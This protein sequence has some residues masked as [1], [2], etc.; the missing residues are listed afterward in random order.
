CLSAG[1][2]KRAAALAEAAAQTAGGDLSKSLAVHRAAQDVLLA[3]GK[4]E[5]LVRLYDKFYN[6]NVADPLR[7]YLRARVEPDPDRRRDDLEAALAR[8]TDLFWA[9][10]DLAE[11]YAER[12][13]WSH[14]AR[15]AERAVEIRPGE[16]TAWNVLGH[17]RLEASRF[18]DDPAD[19]KALAE[20]AREA[21]AKAVELAPTLA[22]ARYNLG[23]VLRALGDAA[24]AKASWEEALRLRA[25]FAEAHVALGHLAAREGDLD[26]AMARY[27][28]ALAARPGYG[29]AHNNLAVAYYRRKHYARATKHLALAE[30]AGYEPTESFKR[31]LVRATEEEA[32]GE[33]RKAVEA[34]KPECVR[35]LRA[36]GKETIAVSERD[37]RILWAALQGLA[38]RD[39]HGGVRLG[40]R[41]VRG[42][43]VARYGEAARLQVT[44]AGGD[45]RE[46]LVVVRESTKTGR[47][48]LVAWVADAGYRWS[49]VA[50]DLVRTAAR[51]AG[52]E[53]ALPGDD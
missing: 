43:V 9:A 14:A 32:F 19:R 5:R 46:L 29:A 35:L 4:S 18:L 44:P 28:K 37:R 27:E 31:V 10:Y 47:R 39:S 12:G 11:L 52:L 30:A 51:L 25:D 3:A 33:F 38:F 40:E 20:R 15:K 8:S 7:R 17:L 42:T 50:P 36:G 2:A 41:R 1:D 48:T 24:A 23:L 22:E 53:A 6:E 49:A 13:E 16:A 34:V 26:E 21:L 45:K